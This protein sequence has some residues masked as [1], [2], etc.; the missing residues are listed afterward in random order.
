MKPQM[1]LMLRIIWAALL[2]GQI[3]F[4]ALILAGVVPHQHQTQ[5]IFGYV[6]LIML[7]TIVPITFG[8]RAFQLRRAAD[9]SGPANGVMNGNI[10]FWAGCEGVSFASMVFAVVTSWSTP[11]I[12]AVAIAMALQMVTFPQQSAEI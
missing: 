3:I 12:C 11:L 6:S 10:I 4:L 2:M 8:I 1:L 9:G 5:P 7:V